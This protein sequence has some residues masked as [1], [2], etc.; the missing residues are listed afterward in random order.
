[1]NQKVN[2]IIYGI[3]LVV[4]LVMSYFLAFRNPT[5]NVPKFDATP[6]LEE[7]K[8]RDLTISRLIW[9][10]GVHERR[11]KY[12]QDKIKTL[13]NLKPKIIH[14]YE[15]QHIIVRDGTVVQLDSII[16]SKIK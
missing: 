9:K 16:R 5:S 13:D 14:H 10:I 12:L 1:M 11:E 4:I 2:Y 7:I 8:Q 6:Y 15:K 3:L